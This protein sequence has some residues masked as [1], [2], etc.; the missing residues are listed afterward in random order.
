MSGV[1]PTGFVRLEYNDIVTA[2]KNALRSSPA[3]GPTTDME[4][5]SD[6]G[7][8]IALF[9]EREA[10][11]W[12]FIETVYNILDPDAAEGAAL[13]NLCKILGLN[14][15]PATYTTINETFYGT[16]GTSILAGTIVANPDTG[17]Q[18]TTDS[19]IIITG[20]STSVACTCTVAGAVRAPA[21]SITQMVTIVSGVTSCTNAADGDV[22]A[23]IENDTDYRERREESLQAAGTGP[24]DAIAARLVAEVVGMEE[25]I[26]LEN[27]ASL[28]DADGRPGHSFEAVVRGTS[29]HADILNKIWELKPA[30]IQTCTTA[31]GAYAKSG[32]VTDA[33]GGIHTLYY[34]LANDLDV[35]MHVAID[36]T[37]DFNRGCAMVAEVS[38]VTLADSTAYTCTINGV[39]FSFTSPVGPTALQIVMGLMAAINAGVGLS[40]VPVTATLDGDLLV[41]TADYYGYAFSCSVDSRLSVATKQEAEGDQLTIIE[42][43]CDHADD[44]QHLGKN[45]VCRN[46][47]AAVD[48]VGNISDEGTYGIVITASKTTAD[49]AGMSTTNVEMDANEYADFDSTRVT[50]AATL[51]P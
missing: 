29:D 7:Q 43:I 13:D 38:V 49:P 15:L 22:G 37:A 39:V 18:F 12:E 50:V 47:F 6:I 42:A 14:R 11:L 23:G 35:Y 21:G 2:I 33:A 16:N 10:L 4:N 45:V 20:G 19:N 44:I 1:E 31:T 46:Y 30:G 40:F 36:V 48:E 17:D 34:S 5:D 27:A 41:L 8:L 24:A 51:V 28:P 3:W 32:A 25:A 26:V 9:A